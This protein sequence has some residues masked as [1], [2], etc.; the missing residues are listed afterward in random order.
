[1]LTCQF[2]SYDSV[3]N[4]DTTNVTRFIFQ[5]YRQFYV[6]F[7]IIFGPIN[8]FANML[9]M[10]VLTRKELRSTYNYLFFAM[11]L[12]HTIVVVFLVATVTRSSF[13]S[14]CDPN[15]NTLL[16]A[17][18]NIVASN[19]MDIFRAHSSWVA[20]MI[21][22]LRY[23][24]IRKRRQLDYNFRMI[25]LICLIS[26]T[27]LLIASTPVFLSTSIQWRPMTEVCR[28]RNTTNLVGLI[29][30]VVRESEWVYH[31]DCLLLR[32]TYFISGT[33]YNGVPCLL[34]FVLSILL[35]RHLQLIRKEFVSASKKTNDQSGAD[36]RVTKMMAVILITTIISQMP[37]T[38][39]NI[40]VAFLPNGFRANI[41]DRLSN[42]IMTIMLVTSACNLFVYLSMSQ[43]FRE[44]YSA[45]KFSFLC[46]GK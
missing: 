44:V 15:N 24:M 38:V 36:D 8:I 45:I 2:I 29:V 11:T 34:L 18:F 13:T 1:N 6:Y 41:V 26:F 40:L 19:A 37:H 35:L 43:K 31:H 32:V 14:N 33:L 30:P 5:I 39:L 27:L 22:T 7:V 4:T 28:R 16:L 10:F 17:I 20:V 9:S 46:M 23:V 42:I 3:A 12:D 21:A 25:F